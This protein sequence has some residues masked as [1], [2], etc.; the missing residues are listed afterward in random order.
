MLKAE[1]ATQQLKCMAVIVWL[2]EMIMVTDCSSRASKITLLSPMPAL[3]IIHK[4]FIE[5]TEIYGEFL[6]MLTLS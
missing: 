4:D 5:C 1:K 3:I 6:S 2:Q